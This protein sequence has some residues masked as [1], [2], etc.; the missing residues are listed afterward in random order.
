MTRHVTR[1]ALSTL[2]AAIALGEPK[3]SAHAR[4][5]LRAGERLPVFSPGFTFAAGPF[6]GMLLEEPSSP[7]CQDWLR[8]LGKRER[9]R[10]EETAAI[11]GPSRRSVPI[12]QVGSRGR[13]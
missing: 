3:A 13:G 2:P 8:L 11:G 1:K 5:T 10:T 7:A 4:V 9:F 12:G 6:P